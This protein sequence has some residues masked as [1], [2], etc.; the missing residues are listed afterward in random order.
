LLSLAIDK[1]GITILHT[2][3]KP[4]ARFLLTVSTLF[5]SLY[6]LPTWAEV[7]GY[8]TEIQGTVTLSNGTKLKKKSIIDSSDTITT[9]K[10]SRVVLAMIDD[11]TVELGANTSLK[12]VTYRYKKGKNNNAAFMEVIRGFFSTT[13]GKIGKDKDD[14]NKTSTPL[15]TI[16]IQGTAYR[17]L[18]TETE[19][20]IGAYK[21]TILLEEKPNFFNSTATPQK[22]QLGEA[23]K[24][25]IR[26]PA[27]NPNTRG[28]MT[29]SPRWEQF[30][31][32]PNDFPKEFQ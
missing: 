10:D 22:T 5:F 3:T 31:T 18:V 23:K 8:V 26:I 7:A 4:L 6:A 29:P 12:L 15:T 16:G 27:P 25:F 21:G 20:L 32:K 28:F 2:F 17:I 9:E 11:A 13:S 1:R 19:E 14:Q 24:H 30:D